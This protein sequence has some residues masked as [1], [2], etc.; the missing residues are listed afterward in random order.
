MSEWFEVHPEM[1]FEGWLERT[2]AGAEAPV[3]ST[4]EPH[5]SFAADYVWYLFL[6]LLFSNILQSYMSLDRSNIIKPFPSLLP[7]HYDDGKGSSFV[8]SSILSSQPSS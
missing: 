3:S 6:E 2:I 4:E 7:H 1:Q 5:E 8:S